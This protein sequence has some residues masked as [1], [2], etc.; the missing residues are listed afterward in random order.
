MSGAYLIVDMP[1]LADLWSAVSGGEALTLSAVRVELRD[2]GYHVVPRAFSLSQMRDIV[3]D[4]AA[5][6]FRFKAAEVEVYE[7]ESYGAISTRRDE[8][9]YSVHADITPGWRQEEGH[10]GMIKYIGPISRGPTLEVELRS[11]QGWAQL[12]SKR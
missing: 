2:D 4:A 6:V 5:G 9:W 10:S 11:F 8:R 7:H 3:Y 12:L 1:S